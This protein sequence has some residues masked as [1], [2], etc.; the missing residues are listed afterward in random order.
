[1]HGAVRFH[2]V[3]AWITMAASAYHKPSGVIGDV[4]SRCVPDAP[5]CDQR[6]PMRRDRM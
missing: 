6:G 5:I 2:V 4:T 3:R 1:L